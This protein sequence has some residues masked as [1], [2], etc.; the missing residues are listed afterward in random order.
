MSSVRWLHDLAHLFYPRLC[1]ACKGT[2][3]LVEEQICLKCQYQMPK[4]G[5]Y[6][7]LEN[8]FTEIFWGRVRM[9]TGAAMYYFSKSGRVQKLIHQLKYS[10]QPEIGRQLGVLY[11]QLLATQPHYT[12]VDAIVPVPL[13]PRKQHLRGYNQAAMFGKGLSESMQRPLFSHALYRPIFTDTQTRKSRQERLENAMRSFDVQQ[14]D[15]LRGKHILL[16][17]DV[18]TTGA[19]LEACASCVLELPG[20]RVSMATI[21]MAGD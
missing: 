15:L 10:N 14:P 18:L 7:L 11:G 12:A 9:E 5:Q 8:A 2:L 19:T 13:H 4:T 1:L 17:D 21:A 3:P 20:T 6:A 16:V